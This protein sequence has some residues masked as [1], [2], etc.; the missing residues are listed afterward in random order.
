MSELIQK[1]DNRA[2]IH[3]KLLTGVSALAL[4]VSFT[5]TA[6]AEDA[7]HPPLWIELGGQLERLDS[8]Q[9]A[10]APAFFSVSTPDILA[11][12]VDAQKP[13]LYSFGE[14]GKLT[15][16]PMGSDWLFSASIRYGRASQTKHLHHQTDHSHVPITLLGQYLT[17][18]GG[19]DLFKFGEGQGTARESHLVLDFQAGKDVG[20]GLFGARGTSQISAGVRFAQFTSGSH[21]TLHARPT[22][23]Y[24]VF[25]K[26]GKYNIDHRHYRSNTAVVQS[27]RD[28]HAVGPSVS[29]NASLP[30][31]GNSSSMSIALDWGMNAALLFGRQRAKVYHQTAGYYGIHAKYYRHSS[32]VNPAVNKTRTR[33]V[34]IPN[35]GG[36][37]GISFRYENAKVSFGYR[38]DFFFNAVDTGWDTGK[39]SMVGFHGPFASISIGVG[40]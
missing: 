23:V 6:Q 12:M 39:A 38:G 5:G 29:W 37:A 24:T 4:V 36:F 22:Y 9:K 20:L 2:A 21:T 28:T 18:G 40:N 1:N 7:D 33:N 17:S 31:A 10:F 27:R 35:V 13:P 25:N 19:I 30:V 11:P 3:W 16:Q 34:V 15:F 14:N 8:A 32:Y 26:P